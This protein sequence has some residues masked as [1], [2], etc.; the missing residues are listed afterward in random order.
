MPRSVC[1]LGGTGFIGSALAARLATDGH[2]MKILSRDPARH[3]ELLVLPT[4]SL[5]RADVHEPAV[6]AREFRGCDVI[7]NLVGILNE[8]GFGGRG[9]RRVHT[10]LTEKVVT[11]CKSAGVRR[12]LHMSALNADAGRAPSHYLR[13][14]GGAED[15][16]RRECAA[17]P[18]FV[19]F[20]PSVV[21]GPRDSLVNRFARLLRLMPGVFPLACA[22]AKFAPVYVGDVV[23]AFARCLGDPV[24][25]RR[26]F[27]L[28]G[29]EVLTLG[30]IVRLTA[31]ASGT[32]RLIL[33]L[34]RPLARLQAAIM[35]FVPGRPF[36]TDNYRSATVDS[37]CTQNGFADLGIEP[38][39]LR[40]ML[41]HSLH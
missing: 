17:G 36:S 5:V 6:L 24:L 40:A 13:S 29:P 35:D 26:S 2:A 1:V 32:K 31:R 28:C 3:R 25:A 34:P 38:V 16:I 30:D 9:F 15:V 21:F 41:Q 11:A 18:E 8:R 14:K 12:Y 7:V 22:D 10:E 23:E 4:L 37:V 19:I 27:E 33:P 39:S 20:R